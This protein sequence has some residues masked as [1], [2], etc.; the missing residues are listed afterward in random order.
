MSVTTAYIT[1]DEF[2]RGT[3]AAMF[4][5]LGVDIVQEYLENAAIVMDGYL[6][7]PFKLPLRSWKSDI[8]RVNA[9]LATFLLKIEQCGM[10]PNS[11]EY[12]TLRQQ[13][14][15]AMLFLK[16]AQVRDIRPQVEDS[17]PNSQEYQLNVV[18][19]K[20]SGW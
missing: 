5:H 2:L 19:S 12:E 1:T 9:Q 14:D 8:R 20:P 10:Q 6:S 16:K 15:D 7:T 17:T 11:K 18:T 13:Y 4:Q 3:R